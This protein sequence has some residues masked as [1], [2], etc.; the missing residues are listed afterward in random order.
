MN[1]RGKGLLTILTGMVSLTDV[2]VRKRVQVF[3]IEF[4]PSEK[5][6][7]QILFDRILSRFEFF[8]FLLH[9]WLRECHQFFTLERLSLERRD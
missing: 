6:V 8:P 3:E 5:L 7:S 1:S 9:I 2:R 4:L